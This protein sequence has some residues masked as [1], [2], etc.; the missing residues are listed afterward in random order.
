MNTAKTQRR[1][2]PAPKARQAFK[3]WEGSDGSFS[4]FFGLF[5]CQTADMLPALAPAPPK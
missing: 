4:R 3:R 2:F 1:I 5:L